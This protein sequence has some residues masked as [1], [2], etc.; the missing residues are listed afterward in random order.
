MGASATLEPIQAAKR[1][2]KED[3]EDPDGGF[4]RQRVT[5]YYWLAG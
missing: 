3:P 4:V 5:S 1:S 2:G